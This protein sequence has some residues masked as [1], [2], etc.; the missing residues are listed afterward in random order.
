MLR[1]MNLIRVPRL[2]GNLSSISLSET[3]KHGKIL[4]TFRDCLELTS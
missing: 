4:G 2:L 3:V 1:Q